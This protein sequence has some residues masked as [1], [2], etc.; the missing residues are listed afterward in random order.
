MFEGC[1]RC[2]SIC[3]KASIWPFSPSPSVELGFLQNA[4]SNREDNAT[5]IKV[6]DYLD[7]EGGSC[8]ILRNIAQ[9]LPIDTT[10]YAKRL[11]SLRQC[12]FQNRN[13]L[14][15]SFKIF[16]LF[17]IATTSLSYSCL[18]LFILYISR[19]RISRISF[20]KVTGRNGFLVLYG[21][22]SLTTMFQIGRHLAL[23]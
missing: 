15:I 11:H 10:S 7:P 3:T 4:I 12:S 22:R 8:K 2:W 1:F 14:S 6:I 13:N 21:I 19:L 23:S 9:Y 17:Q 16:A 18:L 20:S 5:V